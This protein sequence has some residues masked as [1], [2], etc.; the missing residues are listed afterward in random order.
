MK[1]QLVVFDMDGTI[2]DTLGDLTD[3]INAV[4]SENG[5]P[6]RTEREVRSYLGNGLRRL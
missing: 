2:L 3:S 1:Y 6:G 5:L 4:L